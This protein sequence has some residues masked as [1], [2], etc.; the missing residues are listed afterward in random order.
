MKV[1]TRSLLFLII[2]AAVF[3]SCDSPFSSVFKSVVSDYTKPKAN[4]NYRDNEAVDRL[5]DIVITFSEVMDRES[6]EVSGTLLSYS[7]PYVWQ[8]TAD[9]AD[10]LV[11]SPESTWPIGET[12]SIKLTCLDPDGFSIEPIDITYGVVENNIYV[13]AQN[14][15]DGKPGTAEQPK[16]SI[17]AAIAL[18]ERLYET[19]TIH[20]AEGTYSINDGPLRIRKD[21]SLI[22][23]YKNNDWSVKEPESH[24]TILDTVSGDPTEETVLVI[25]GAQETVTVDG[26]TFNVY[27]YGIDVIGATNVSIK[28]NVF[29]FKNFYNYTEVFDEELGIEVKRENPGQISIYLKSAHAIIENNYFTLDL[30]GPNAEMLHIWEAI[31]STRSTVDIIGNQIECNDTIICNYSTAIDIQDNTSL[32]RI[33]SNT[34][35][36]MGAEENGYGIYLLNAHEVDVYN[37]IITGLTGKN[38]QEALSIDGCTDI[39]VEKNYINAGIVTDVSTN[40]ISYGIHCY[41]SENIAMYN[42]IIDGG[43]SEYDTRGIQVLHSEVD[44]KNNTI[45]GGGKLSTGT[46]VYSIGLVFND[47]TVSIDNNIFF[48][49][50]SDFQRGVLMLKLFADQSLPTS[51]RNN[52][53]FNCTDSVFRDVTDETNKINLQTATEI[54][55]HLTGKGLDPLLAMGNIV[56]VDP[57]LSSEYYLSETTP[58]SIT[59]G[60]YNFSAVFSNDYLGNT[61][62]DPW[63]IGAVEKD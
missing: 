14:G 57:Q 58:S 11:F 9:G 10:M 62:T 17:Y 13:A 36:F 63:S 56:D 20:V 32:C 37:N 53:F 19:A 1:I 4:L 40:P 6:M 52:C 46:E 45:N 34:I 50:N 51:F 26:F 33:G 38:S 16:K 55:T 49:N 31:L 54:E 15:D 29:L 48:T 47:T 8:Q 22:G 7:K 41:E 60:G 28:N 24:P 59:E 30:D 18:A 42:N 23:G 39:R 27:E 2:A 21:I 5:T 43:V 25:E 61:R 35:Q 3:F 12:I 44:I